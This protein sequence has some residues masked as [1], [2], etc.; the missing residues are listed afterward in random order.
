M[1][2]TGTAIDYALLLSKCSQD[3]L[4]KASAKLGDRTAE[5]AL[6]RGKVFELVGYFDDAV[7]SYEDAISLDHG[8]DEARARLALA[9]LKSQQ[10]AKAL[11]TAIA[12]TAHNQKLQL[13]ALSTDERV[14]AMTILGDALVA[15]NRLEDA[16]HA[17]EAARAIDAGDTY[18][19]GRLAEVYLAIGESGK[20]TALASAFSSNPRF[21]NVHEVLVLG[22]TSAGLFRLVD[23]ASLVGRIH[24][25]AVGRPL[26]VDD[27]ARLATR[28]GNAAWCANLDGNFEGSRK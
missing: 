22:Q 27:A 6:A 3:T 14:S 19:A 20:A 18:A 23:R 10:P 1:H 21:F 4:Q 11:A 2:R 12:L 13:H 5:G 25:V 28:S 7:S 16:V 17:Y 24:S 26:L 15:N 8:L 9:Q